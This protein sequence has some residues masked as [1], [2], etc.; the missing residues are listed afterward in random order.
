MSFTQALNLFK[1]AEKQGNLDHSI[2]KRPTE[3]QKKEII[4]R[5][6]AKLAL[7]NGWSKATLQSCVNELLNDG[8]S[9][10]QEPKKFMS[11]LKEAKEKTQEIK[12]G[13]D[14]ILALNLDRQVKEKMTLLRA[15]L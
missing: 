14:E 11:Y 8:I 1:S 7:C 12:K 3:S 4:K 2:I 13:V 5:I 15:M 6:N 9:Q 10:N